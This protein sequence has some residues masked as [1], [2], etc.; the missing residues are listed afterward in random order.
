M[1]T[2]DFSTGIDSRGRLICQEEN[3]EPQVLKE[4]ADY[5]LKVQSKVSHTFV[6]AAGAKDT[7]VSFGSLTS[8]KVLFIFSEEAISFKVN[9]IGSAS[10]NCNPFALMMSETG[11]ISEL[12]LTNLGIATTVTVWIG[13]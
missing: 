3:L 11:G 1:A 7:Q 10:I 2:P 4:L 5:Y 8:A 13:Q 6:L 9:S 12:Y